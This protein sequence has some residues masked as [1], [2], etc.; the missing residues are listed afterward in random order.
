MAKITEN[1]TF[2]LEDLDGNDLQVLDEALCNY[3]DRHNDNISMHN[4]VARNLLDLVLMAKR[5]HPDY[6]ISTSEQTEFLKAGKD[7]S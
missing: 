5:G 6:K 2:N 7:R 1:K 4:Q 3:I